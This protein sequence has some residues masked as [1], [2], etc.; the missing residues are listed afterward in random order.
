V[1]LKSSLDALGHLIFD[2]G[3]NTPNEYTEFTGFNY[4]EADVTVR[5]NSRVGP[6]PLHADLHLSIAGDVVVE[7]GSAITADGRGFSPGSGPGAAPTNYFPGGGGHGGEGGR[8]RGGA[9]GVRYDSVTSPYQLG[10]GGGGVP[11]AMALAV[12]LSGCPFWV[13]SESTAA[14]PPEAPT[15]EAVQVEA[16]QVGRFCSVRPEC[17][18]AERSE[19]SVEVPTLI[20]AEAVVVESLSTRAR[21]G[22][23][24]LKYRP[25]LGPD[26]TMD[27][28]APS[29]S[30]IPA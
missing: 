20:A 21:S 29:L 28:M 10:S 13:H 27:A 4:F 22:L 2:N 14:L 7:P 24:P 15:V 12:V 16:V 11:P 3:G 8:G 30:M 5:G 25:D 1:Y 17:S 19:Q 26:L 6:P 9:G 23:M 18:A